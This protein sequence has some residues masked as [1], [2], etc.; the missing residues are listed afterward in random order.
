MKS[1]KSIFVYGTLQDLEIMRLVT[2]REAI[3]SADFTAAT[4]HDFCLKTVLNESYPLLVESEGKIVSG[5]I[6]VTE[7]ETEIQRLQYFEDE[8]EYTLSPYI[9]QTESGEKECLL[10]FPTSKIKSSHKSWSYSHW[11][12]VTNKAAF[13]ERVK[14]YMSQ[15]N[16]EFEPKW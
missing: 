7:D 2:Q 9:V 15:F 6:F 12:Q 11:S 4:L 16:T 3:S 14:N 8:E 5:K 13:L 10:F 1:R